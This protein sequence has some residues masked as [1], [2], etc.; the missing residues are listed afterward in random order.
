MRFSKYLFLMALAVGAVTN[1][2][3]QDRWE[4]RDLNHDYARAERIRADLS[5]DQY[6]L[7]EAVRC[8]RYGEADRIRRDMYRD[9]RA[10]DSQMRDIRHDQR[11][12][13]HDSDYRYGW[14]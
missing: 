8:G 2:S 6:R 13:R 10:L 14:R 4:R 3:A 11:E 1:L 5:R 12:L 9:Q 7:N